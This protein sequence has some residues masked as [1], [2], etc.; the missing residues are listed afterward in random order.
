MI[1]NMLK[2]FTLE[3]H[4]LLCNVVTHFSSFLTITEHFPSPPLNVYY[5]FFFIR[6]FKHFS[7]N[8]WEDRF[9]KYVSVV[10]IY[11]NLG[12][13]SKQFLRFSVWNGHYTS[14]KTNFKKLFQQFLDKRF[15]FILKQVSPLSML[16]CM[17]KMFRAKSPVFRTIC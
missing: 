11:E 16:S 6:R 7:I 4:E 3:H 10:Q 13:S 2:I 14:T 12:K 17:G 15:F 1:Y 5:W 9:L 8:C